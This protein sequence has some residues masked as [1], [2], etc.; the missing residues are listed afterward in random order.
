MELINQSAQTFWMLSTLFYRD[1]PFLDPNTSV[2]AL[3]SIGNSKVMPADLRMKSLK[4][5]TQIIQ[6][7][8][9]LTE[10]KINANR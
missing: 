9:N 10:E 7:T 6:K 2:E 5:A 8:Y 1:S 3:E 4:L